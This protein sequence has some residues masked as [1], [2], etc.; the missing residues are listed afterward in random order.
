MPRIMKNNIAANNPDTISIGHLLEAC[1]G[2]LALY[3]EVF[4]DLGY[5]PYD[6]ND[7]DESEENLF[8]IATRAKSNLF[9]AHAAELDVYAKKISSEIA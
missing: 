1:D 2:Y 3:K 7:L 5:V 9:K 8:A 6:F 4:T